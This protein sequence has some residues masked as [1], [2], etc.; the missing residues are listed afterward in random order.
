MDKK[1]LDSDIISAD[2]APAFVRWDL[3]SFDEGTPNVV[4]REDVCAPVQEPEEVEQT[5]VEVEIEEVQPLTLE[6]VEAVRQD[7]YNEGFAVGE[8]D[9][10]RSGQLKAQ[11]EVEAA[12]APRLK[13][14]E[15]IMQ[16]L[17]EPIAHQ[18]AELEQAM[19]E[20]VQ[21]IA[22][23]VI[24]RELQLDSSHIVHVLREALKLVP[25]DGGQ[26]K[27][28]VNPQDF[29]QIKA[30]RE[31]HEENW[32]IVEDEELLPGGCRVE[33][34]HTRVDASMETRLK[35]LT[36]QLLEQQRSLQAEPLEADD[37]QAF[38][39]QPEPVVEEPEPVGPEQS[40]EPLVAVEA[41]MPNTQEA[42]EQ[43]TLDESAELEMDG[44]TAADAALDTPS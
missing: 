31:R 43:E 34:T 3:P 37:V 13:A 24:Q 8:K 30:L 23:Q 4:E 22:T 19:L 14:L 44:Q 6:E 21:I 28:F 9:G 10:F 41:A 36:Q 20:M 27:L 25:L 26:I 35:T 42:S 16:Q 29:E 11:K 38:S 33:A 40:Q 12:L 17:F 2:N 1:K 32:R 5:V 15:A 39:L 7:A 18:D